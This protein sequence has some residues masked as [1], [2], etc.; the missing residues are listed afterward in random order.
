LVGRDR[1]NEIIRSAREGQGYFI[2]HEESLRGE[3]GCC[4][5]FFESYGFDIQMYQIASR[6]SAYSN[7][8]YVIWIGVDGEPVEQ[9]EDS[10]DWAGKV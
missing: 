6:L 2:C 5:A 10:P 9:P 8:D 4:R 7:A 1:K 3:N